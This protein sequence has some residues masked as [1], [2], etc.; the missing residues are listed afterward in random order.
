MSNATRMLDERIALLEAKRTQEWE[1]LKDH[2]H[3]T[4]ESLKP[5]NL[6][7]STF[8]DIVSAP[9]IKQNIVNNLVG[10]ATGYVSRKIVI[11]S[12]HNPIKKVA[13]AILQFAVSKIVGKKMEQAE[14]EKEDEQTEFIP[15]N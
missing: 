9:D 15:T 2:F 3:Q 6:I 11:G 4:T 14:K 12:T 13:G 5:V 8:H 10:L 7:R 1:D